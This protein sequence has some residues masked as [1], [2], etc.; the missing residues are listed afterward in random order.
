M[1]KKKD[2]PKA[3]KK[4]HKG[5][6]HKEKPP[7]D[8]FLPDD[9]QNTPPVEPAETP[10]LP[11]DAEPSTPH[12]FESKPCDTLPTNAEHDAMPLHVGAIP[13][14]TIEPEKVT[15][16]PAPLTASGVVKTIEGCLDNYVVFLLDRNQVLPIPLEGHHCQ[17]T[18]DPPD[19]PAPESGS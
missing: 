8:P 2:K 4:A 18:L 12:G 7:R 5:D 10:Q 1:A 13:L 15:P 11:D 16:L 14:P 19:A 17:I 9:A 3:G 6:Q